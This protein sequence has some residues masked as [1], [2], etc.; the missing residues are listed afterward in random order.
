M[1]IIAQA[2]CLEKNGAIVCKYNVDKS[3]LNSKVIKVPHNSKDNICHFG[4]RLPTQK[5]VYQQYKNNS[6][7]WKIVAGDKIN[8]TSSEES[9]ITITQNKCSKVVKN[10]CI[11]KG[12]NFSGEINKQCF[13]KNQTA[14]INVFIKNC[15]KCQ[16]SV[17]KL[18]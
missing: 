5:N 11:I 15:K 18:Q 2:E 16:F 8:F 1:P 13:D 10:E 3:N 9:I 6:S 7:S 12:N 4:N 17:Y 14:Y